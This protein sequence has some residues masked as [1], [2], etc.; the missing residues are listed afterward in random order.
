MVSYSKVK[1]GYRVI[2]KC[3]MTLRM[4]E[5]NIRQGSQG[6]RQVSLKFFEKGKEKAPIIFSNLS[7]PYELFS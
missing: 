7:L 1:D 3:Q 2:L 5:N 6:D 4:S